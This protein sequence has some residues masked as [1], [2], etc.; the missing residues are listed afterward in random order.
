MVSRICGQQCPDSHRFVA[1]WPSRRKNIF[2][3]NAPLSEHNLAH[4]LLPSSS[5]SR[6]NEKTSKHGRTSDS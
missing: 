2:F 3:I 6:A 5:D 1:L 4:F